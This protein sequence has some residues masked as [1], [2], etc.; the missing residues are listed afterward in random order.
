[1]S[2][3]YDFEEQERIA[4]LKAWWEDNRMYVLGAVAGLI[5]AF[6]GYRG[7]QYWQARQAEDAA[8]MFTPVSEASKGKDVKRVSDLAQAL[9]DKHSGS[10]YASQAGLVAAKAA[11]DAGD[12][13]TAQ[14]HLEWVMGNGVQEH[15]GVA[16]LRLAGVL[17]E[18]RKYDDA[19]KLLDQN[20][21]GAFNPL[22]ADMR[23]DVMLAQGRLDEAR[24]A[25]KLAIEKAD[26]R[27]PVRSIAETKLN[28]LGGPQ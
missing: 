11:F 25:Y 18:Q 7:W 21:D 24:S 19:L 9:E 5:I 6:A 16:R 15:R 26:P 13:A 28:A 3:S 17:L 23:G 20:K 1:M 22:V 4:E 2:G 10:F 27:S 14:K 8:A 12:Y